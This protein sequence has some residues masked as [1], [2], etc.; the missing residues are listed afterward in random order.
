MAARAVVDSKE[1]FEESKKYFPTAL[2]QF[3]FFDKYARYDYEK[4]RR[5]T[6]VETVDRAV[7][8]LTELS[9][10]K[11][12][13][14]TYARLRSGI[15][16]MHASPSMRLLAMAGPAARRQ[17]I[18][19]FNC[20]F[21]PIDCI[22]AWVEA[23][24]ISMSGCG[25]GFSVEQKFVDKLP[26]VGVYVENQAVPLYSIP[27]TTEGW[28][29][30]LRHGLSRW[31]EGRD[32]RFDYS[33]V[34]PAGTPLKTKGG[35]A[36]GPEPL[37][38]L[39]DFARETILGAQGRKLTPLECH[40]IMC[41]VGT[42]AV[43]GG[44]R[45]T[46]MISIFDAEDE[47]M[48]N[49]KNGEFHPRRW[50][51]N[52]SAVWH[53]DT[54]DDQISLQMKEMYDGM[55]GEPGI[56]SR[57][58]GNKTK[59]ERR[60]ELP[61]GGVNPCGEIFLRP[62]QFCNLSI[63]IAREDDT[64]ESLKDKVEIA[65]IIGTIQS[66]GTNYPGLRPIWKENC[67]EE[68]LLGVDINGSLDCKILRED[69]GSIWRKLRDHAVAVN[70]RYA[71]ALGI[72]QSTSVT[73]V[74]PSGNSSTLFNCASGLHARHGDY[75][76]RRVRVGTTSPLFATLRDAGVPLVPE[77]GQTEENAITYVASFP[78]KSPDGAITKENWNAE[79]QLEW[80][81]L[82]KENWTEHNPSCT[83]T[84]R[85]EEQDFITQWVLKH[86]EI[87]G[88]L[89]FLPLSEA[90][91]D[92]MPYETITKEKYEELL[93]QFPKDID[94]SRI[95]L[96]EK[97]DTTTSAQELACMSGACEIDIVPKN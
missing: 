57:H 81:K 36:S 35:Q 50:N 28:A 26:E 9:D 37:K 10:N 14:Q 64:F 88:G 85:P 80:W 69:D 58:S 60:K 38:N 82:I 18:C 78:V 91:Y 29:E 59:P 70:K 16:N 89:S 7:A 77:N 34:R 17:N 24:I 22:D 71:E 33:Q 74:K 32:V 46:A 84:Y 72:N 67:D 8:F 75:Y 20:S 96:Y 68:R 39:L 42:A 63:A 4:G 12:D 31:F 25:V 76:I 6:W 15:L 95:M 19:I 66:M 90:K 5:E 43:S 97:R 13:A 51:A 1:V 48:R 93:A 2:Q 30:S 27:D 92:N 87:I 79:K 61:E 55:R 73:C 41:E 21:M 40:D 3:Q 94:F 52:N 47:E 23:L 49:C 65:T 86:K 83:I 54:S 11:L 56:F 44:V 45:R 62:N 53:E